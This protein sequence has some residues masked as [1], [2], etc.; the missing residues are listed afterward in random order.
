MGKSDRNLQPT[1][2]VANL[3]TILATKTKL[4]TKLVTKIKSV[5]KIATNTKSIAK[6]ATNFFGRQSVANVATK[7]DPVSNMVASF[8]HKKLSYHKNG[9][10]FADG[11]C[12][13]ANLVSKIKLVA[14]ITT[15]TKSVAKVATN[16]FGR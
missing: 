11:I 12:S 4:V 16:F 9:W 3:A 6:V 5:A 13:V 14:K 8:K 10:T 15:N 1:K 7:I 2:T